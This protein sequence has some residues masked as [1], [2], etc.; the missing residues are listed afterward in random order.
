MLLSSKNFIEERKNY[1]NTAELDL[2]FCVSFPDGFSI[3]EE[4]KALLPPVLVLDVRHLPQETD[5]VVILQDI[6]SKVDS[7]EK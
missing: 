3:V 2:K 1:S 4:I 6:N 5:T 7:N